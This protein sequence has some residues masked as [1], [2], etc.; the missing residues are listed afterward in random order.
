MEKL[1][2]VAEYIKPYLLPPLEDSMYLHILKPTFSV[3]GFT[4][5][6]SS[7]HGRLLCSPQARRFAML[8]NQPFPPHQSQNPQWMQALQSKLQGWIR[9]EIIDE[10][11]C[12]EDKFTAQKLYEEF[13]AL[14]K[15][16]KV[17]PYSVPQRS[18]SY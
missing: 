2:G 3:T 9:H 15:L 4:S 13:L 16:A 1:R 17:Q 10:D 6:T 12:D 7:C 5:F 8:S 14:E 11:P 18:S